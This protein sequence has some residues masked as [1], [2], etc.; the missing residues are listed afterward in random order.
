MRHLCG[1]GRGDAA[2]QHGLPRVLPRGHAHKDR[3]HPPRVREARLPQPR[4]QVQAR[5]GHDREPAEQRHHEAL[6]APAVPAQHLDRPPADHRL[7]GAAHPDHRLLPDSRRA[8]GHRQPHPAEHRD[9]QSPGEGSEEG[10]SAH[11]SAR[12]GRLGGRRRDQGDQA[13]RLGGTLQGEAVRAPERGARAS[14]EGGAPA[15]R[16]HDHLLL[17][18]DPH[19]HRDLWRLR[20]AR[21]AAPPLGRLPGA[22]ALQPPAIP[23]PHAPDAD[24][25]HHQRQGVPQAPPGLHQPRGDGGRPT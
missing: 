2:Q 16:Q 15:G 20:G 11:R 22:V 1:V 8:R 13:V 14:E 19:L 7:H 12:Q 17:L 3:D 23:H 10:G 6:D 9:R 25:Q 21:Q 24:H 4:R 18:A 5:L